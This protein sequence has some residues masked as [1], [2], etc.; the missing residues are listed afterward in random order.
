M[1]ESHSID[2]G[3]IPLLSAM[4]VISALIGKY[5]SSVLIHSI[6]NSM[7]GDNATIAN[8]ITLRDTFFLDLIGC[9]VILHMVQQISQFNTK[10]LQIEDL[11]IIL[12]LG[13]P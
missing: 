5:S 11:F 8:T 3:F 10:D 12:M 9:W 1:P 7:I 6:P 4:R 13:S 2:K